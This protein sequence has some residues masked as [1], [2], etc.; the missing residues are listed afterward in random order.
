MWSR[1]GVMSIWARV[2][3][4]E[5]RGGKG[6]SRGEGVS[7]CVEYIVHIVAIV[8]GL[9]FNLDCGSKGLLIHK[10]QRIVCVAQESS[11]R[12]WRRITISKFQLFHTHTINHQTAPE[13]LNHAPR[14]PKSSQPRG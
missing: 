8:F 7:I 5:G 10:L 4:R 1:P 11:S 13:R 9:L 3:I 12:I 14:Y 6:G 2:M